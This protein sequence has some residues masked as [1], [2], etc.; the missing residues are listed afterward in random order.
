MEQRNHC[1]CTFVGATPQRRGW[2]SEKK[3][4]EKRPAR[5]QSE[6]VRAATGFQDGHDGAGV[7][8]V[9][10]EEGEGKWYL[11]ITSARGAVVWWTWTLSDGSQRRAT[12]KVVG[13]AVRWFARGWVP[14]EC[15]SAELARRDHGGYRRW[16]CD[17]SPVDSG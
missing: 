8:D 16:S 13:R 1:F 15:S 14:S 7:G 12:E 9:P 4:K 2:E 3:E 11:L 17:D 10:A 6:N 5:F